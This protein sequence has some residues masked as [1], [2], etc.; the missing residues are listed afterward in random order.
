MLKICQCELKDL[1]QLL[2]YSSSKYFVNIRT[3]LIERI[4][5]SLTM[6]EERCQDY[7]M[8]ALKIAAF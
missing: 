6:L 4:T 5:L 8:I 1:I 7:I 2:L 3:F